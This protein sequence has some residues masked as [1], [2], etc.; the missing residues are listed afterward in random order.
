MLHNLS[1]I[2]LCCLQYKLI[3][4]YHTKVNTVFIHISIKAKK[5][6]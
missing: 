1:Q 4:Q 3:K 5:T 2:F 6:K